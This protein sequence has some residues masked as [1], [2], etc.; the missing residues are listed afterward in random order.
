MAER[1]PREVEEPGVISDNLDDRVLHGKRRK[2][3]TEDR[4]G[5]PNQW[6]SSTYV[7]EARERFTWFLLGTW[8]AVQAIGFTLMAVLP[9]DIWARVQSTLLYVMGGSLSLVTVAVQHWFAKGAKK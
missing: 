1:L 4:A 3:R 5:P 6:R 8:A 9:A 7:Q 2:K